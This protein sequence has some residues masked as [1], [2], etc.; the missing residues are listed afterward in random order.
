LQGQHP[1]HLQKRLP[2]FVRFC[3]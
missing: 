1:Q 2:T 3:C